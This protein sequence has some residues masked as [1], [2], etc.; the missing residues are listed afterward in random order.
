MLILSLEFAVRLGS[1][2]PNS[3]LCVPMY[4]HSLGALVPSNWFPYIDAARTHV[5]VNSCHV[6][7]MHCC[8]VP[9]FRMRKLYRHKENTAPLLLAACVLRVLPSSGFTCHNIV[10]CMCDYRRGFGLQIGFTDHFT[11][12]LVTTSNYSSI[13]DL[14]AFQ[15]TIAYSKSFPVCC[16]FTSR[17]LVTASNSGNSSA[18][19]VTSLL[20]CSQLHRLSI[21]FTDSLATDLQLSS[22][23]DGHLTPTTPSPLHGLTHKWA[24]L[25]LTLLQITRLFQPSRL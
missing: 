21:L 22:Q 5:T 3:Q 18:F 10:T 13:A 25:Q 24:L 1:P 17:S 15:I 20:A 16:V 4:F 11:T 14:Y 9:S 6:I 7:A 2:G 19:A 23:S 8:G 12:R